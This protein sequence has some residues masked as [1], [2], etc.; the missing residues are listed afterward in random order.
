MLSF[1]KHIAIRIWLTAILGGLASLW[2]LPSFQMGIGLQWTPL[3]VALIMIIAFLLIGWV[4]NHWGVGM[5]ERLVREAGVFERDGML[6]EAEAKFRHALAVFD[7]FLISPVVKKQEADALMARVARFYVARA[8][9]SYESEAFL[10]AYLQSN[11]EDEEVAENW[12]EQLESRGGLKEEHQEL[13]YLIGSAQGNNRI[14]QAALARYYLLMERT[15]FPALQTYRRV[16]TFDEQLPPGFIDNL[17]HLLLREKRID[18]WALEIYLRAI[19][20]NDLRSEILRGIAACARWLAPTERNKSLL[21]KAYSCLEGIDA[22]EVEKMCTGF[23]PPIPTDT[24]KAVERPDRKK[25]SFLS[26][27]GAVL[28]TFYED[29]SA[30]PVWALRRIRFAGRWVMQSK[31]AKRV[32]SGLMVA[33]LTAGVIV[34]VINTVGHLVKSETPVAQKIEKAPEQI[35]D[36][37]TLQVAAY[38]EPAY[39]KSY[40]EKLKEEGLD[41]YWRE[42]ISANKKWYQV[43]I[44][45]FA[46]KKSA[47]DFGESLK[48]RGTIDDY[49]VANFVAPVK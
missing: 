25:P 44:S 37:F 39:A 42:A 22:A 26:A 35:T 13:A 5:V 1:F 43:R 21:Q 20:E 4:S 12:I 32:F 45:H 41:A 16:S 9:K 19:G 15:D 10:E 17:A 38:L 30:L 8:A 28:Q 24:G 40:V 7:S 23:K 48:A 33:G 46:D 6:S 34:L 3:P 49:F 27:A 2:L 11:P 18:D 47:R 36:P 14:I 29:I 31:K